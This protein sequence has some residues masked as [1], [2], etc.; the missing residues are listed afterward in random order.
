V[1][2]CVLA[3]TCPGGAEDRLNAA[4][5]SGECGVPSPLR[6]EK[7]RTWPPVHGL[8]SLEDSLASPV[9]TPRGPCGAG[10]GHDANHPRQ[11]LRHG[12]G[13]RRHAA[14]GCV[15]PG[16]VAHADREHLHADRRAGE[17]ELGSA[18]RNTRTENQVLDDR[19]LKRAGAGSSPDEPV[20]RHERP[21]G[22]KTTKGSKW[23]SSEAR[24]RS[25][26]DAG[27]A[28][29]RPEHLSEHSH[30]IGPRRVA[31][32]STRAPVKARASRSGRR[33]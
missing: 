9:A 29:Q 6:G 2:G 22:A 5:V 12:P 27:R 13:H 20:V 8:R 19:P 18:I 23:Q 24:I 11:T 25:S 28:S 7:R 31:P 1:E 32:V 14:A 26:A 4:V 16:A 33:S 3:L 15:Q 17:C 10:I 21:V 30:A